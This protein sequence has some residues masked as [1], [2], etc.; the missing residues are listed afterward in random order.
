MTHLEP[1]AQ[2]S[3]SENRIL[4]RTLTKQNL[5]AFVTPASKSLAETLQ[6]L[7]AATEESRQQCEHVR[8]SGMSASYQA[9]QHEARWL[10]ITAL[11]AGE[12]ELVVR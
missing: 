12:D 8:R 1:Q 7:V 5:Q 4:R 10:E 3:R 11:I 6:E 9:S 2:K